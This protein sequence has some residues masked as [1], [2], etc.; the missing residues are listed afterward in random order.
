MRNP[1]KLS[2]QSPTNGH[3]SPSPLAC[4]AAT[5]PRLLHPLC[6]LILAGAAALHAVVLPPVW[7]WSNPTPH[8]ANIVDMATVDGLTIQVGD[9]GQ[10]FTS[11]DLVLWIPRASHTTAYLRGVTVFGG[12]LVITGEQG[13][14]LF[15]DNPSDYYLLDLG[16]SDWLESVAASPSLVVAVGDNAAIYTSTNAVVWQRQT[17]SFSDWLRSVA[18]GNGKFVTVGENGLVATSA[19]GLAWTKQNVQ[20]TTHLNRVRWMGNHFLALGNGGL[21]LSSMN[22]NNWQTEPTGATNSLFAASG[23]N[24]SHVA[25]GIREVRW[26]AGTAAWTD[27]VNAALTAPAPSWTYFAGD[28]DGT[29]HLLTGWSGLL[30]EGYQTNATSPMTWRAHS[31]PIRSWLWQVWRTPEH[32]L[33]VGDLGTILSSVNGID[34]EWELVPEAATNSVLLGIGG[35][36]NFFVAAGTQGTLLWATNAYFW[37]ALEPRP[38]AS[39]L[40]GVCYDGTQF[41]VCG[42]DGTLLTSPDGTNWTRQSTPTTTFLMSVTTFPGGYVAVGK[43]GVILTSTNAVHWA[44]QTSGTTNWLSEVRYRNGQLIAV[45]D[46]GTICT[47]TD[48]RHWTPQTS[49][50]SRW[51]NAVDFIEDTWFIVGNQGTVLASP[52]GTNWFSFGTL[53][54][55]S[56]YGLTIHEGQ[57]LTVGSEGVILRSP[58]IPPSTPVEI[59]GFSQ[60][61]GVNA[62]LFTGEPDQQFFL[63]NSHDLTAWGPN[64]L[65]ELLDGT[66]TLLYLQSLPTNA[67]PSQMYRARTLY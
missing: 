52:D 51:L 56:L 46:Q 22:G 32:Y 66:G 47:S 19:D 25:A 10:I 40:K 30:V 48:G 15:A 16:T 13:T 41:I 53:T 61:S 60:A 2:S 28:W 24:N 55:Q 7:R 31:D 4:G 35:S 64:A 6:G 57:L 62:F 1:S 33:A 34:W 49:G 9:R 44:A 5:R 11:H 39:D 26:Q 45:G 63:E 50:T 27:Q 12:R 20:T 59:S 8:G 67:P 18:Y 65:L 42:G 29:S 58:L 43:D 17:V 23:D 38:T 37:H 3:R 36:T 54:R 21:V 14:V